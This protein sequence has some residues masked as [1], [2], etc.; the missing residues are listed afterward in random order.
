MPKYKILHGNYQ[1]FTHNMMPV[2][3]QFDTIF[4][5]PPDNIG[6]EYDEYDDHL[7]DTTYYSL[8]ENLV[9]TCF[10]HA[11]I[12]FISFNAKYFMAMGHILY[13]L[14]SQ[15]RIEPR[16]LIQGFTFGEH[17][18]YDFANNFRP[19]IRL[20]RNDATRFP[21]KTRCESKRMKIGD[22]RANPKGRVPGDVWYTDFLEYA[23]ITGNSKQ[24]R[25]WH[26]TQLV[27]GLIEDCL[28]MSTPENGTV[29]D[30]FAGTGT[31]FRVCIQNGWSCT[32]TDI[33][34]NYCTKIAEENDIPLVSEGIWYKEM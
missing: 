5:D 13:C 3:S 30:P 31:T 1:K 23:R 27:E 22:K 9:R 4:A 32:T 18:N 10:R 29:F 28:L 16:L 7:D 24:R 12:S 2:L 17:N 15:Y 20:M 33:S 11:K 25:K 19:I 6:L 21:D 8:L 34:K 14:A 26:K